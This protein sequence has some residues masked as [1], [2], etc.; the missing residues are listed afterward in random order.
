VN[1]A[2]Q[3]TTHDGF[4]L[5][6]ELR[7]PAQAPK[8]VALLTHAMWVDRRTLDRPRGAGLM[9]VLSARGIACLSFDLRGHGESRPW[10][11]EGARFGYD[12]YVLG[13]AP[14]LLRAARERFPQ[15]GLA[16]VGHSLGAHT[17]LV[18]AGLKPDLAPDAFVCL[19]AN[20]WL[21]QLEPRLLRRVQKGAILSAWAAFTAPRGHF[22]AKPLRLGS[23]GVPWPYV[24]DALTHYLTGHYRS[25]D[26]TRDYLAALR[27]VHAPVLAVLSEGDALMANVDAGAR[28]LRL[29]GST[30]RTL[31]VVTEAE[32]SPPPNHMG[33]VIDPRMA[34]VFDECADFIL[35]RLT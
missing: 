33:L 19:A 5:R 24:R 26:G 11:R 31:R 20:Q 25:A 2:L 34:P 16:H 22:D 12:A 4:T 29:L 15:L 27:R 30:D 1:E 14:A 18:A 32:M 10:P 7:L 3:V 6:G 13:D 8:A 17:T 28:F 35:N 21:P 9:S 23:S